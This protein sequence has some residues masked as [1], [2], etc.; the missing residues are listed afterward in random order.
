MTREDEDDPIFITLNVSQ[1]VKIAAMKR[2]IARHLA[3]KRHA[4]PSGPSNK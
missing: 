4:G 3:A 1:A 2:L